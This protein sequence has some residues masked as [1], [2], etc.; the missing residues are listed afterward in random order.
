MRNQLLKLA[1]FVALLSMV[2]TVYSCTIEEVAPLPEDVAADSGP[3]GPDLE[4]LE[5]GLTVDGTTLAL[6]ATMASATELLGAAQVREMGSAGLVH[7]YPSLGVELWTQG[8]D[9][10]ASIHLVPGYP[11][12]AAD[13]I[14]PGAD[15]ALV[16]ETL[17]VGIADPFG[18]GRHY[19]DRG[20]FVGV[21]KEKVESITLTAAK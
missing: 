20:L 6:G 4:L 5:A 8:S 12:G 10:I 15:D 1:L 18:L 2:A 11:G 9:T 13:Q 14:V 3:T 16:V 19:P 7:S 21:A 17:G